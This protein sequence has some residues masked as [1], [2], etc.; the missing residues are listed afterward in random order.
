MV[1]MAALA[2]ARRSSST[3]A[4]SADAVPREAERAAWRDEGREAEH[5]LFAVGETRIC[6]FNLYCSHEANTNLPSN[7]AVP[8]WSQCDRGL[9]MEGRG[10]EAAPLAA[11]VIC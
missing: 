3:S 8:Y 9:W 11:V 1:S 7:F 5:L 2:A 10:G 6:L 4:R